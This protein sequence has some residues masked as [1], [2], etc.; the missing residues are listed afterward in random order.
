MVKKR[1]PQTTS[2]SE[3]NRI[4]NTQTTRDGKSSS[5]KQ[6]PPGGHKPRKNTNAGITS[7]A[8]CCLVGYLIMSVQRAQRNQIR[9]SPTTMFS[10]INIPTT[11]N[12]SVSSTGFPVLVVGYP[13][14][15]TTSVYNFF[16]CNQ[17][18]TQ[19]YC[20]CNEMQ[21]HPPCRSMASCMLQEWV[22]H[23]HLGLGDG[24][25][26]QYDVYAQ[27]DGERPTK[28]LEGNIRAVLLDAE[29]WTPV[30]KVGPHGHLN[31][32]NKNLPYDVHMHFLP[33]H[34][35]LQQLHEELPTST[36]VLPL[37]SPE[38][39]AKSA[40]RWF[41]M[42]ARMVNEYRYYNRSLE[43]PG[44][45]RAIEFLQSI[46]VE[47]SDFV[48]KFVR[49]HPSHRL[50]EINITDPRAG[51]ILSKAFHGLQASCWGHHNQIGNRGNNVS[52]KL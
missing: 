17:L 36:F 11:I 10:K 14:S 52:L 23:K 5:T 35:Y 40:F 3:E 21:D 50:V 12:H 51:E 20:C 49:E 43:R 6:S 45:A 32:L 28:T 9:K 47:H 18:R 41:Q 13:K 48:R 16:K 22:S 44:R 2:G 15:G 7:I 8:I 25:C 1:A 46:Y 34:F 29:G 39:W 42:R 19:H 30:G 37:R 26:G 38:D 4:P 27:I 24:S 33:Q 31:Y